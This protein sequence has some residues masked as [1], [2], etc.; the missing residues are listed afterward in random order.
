MSQWFVYLLECADGSYYTGITTDLERRV[1]EH[2]GGQRGA[3]YTRARQ[4]V[5]L[6]YHE[7][8][9]SRSEASQREYAIRTL[10]RTGKQHLA[11]GSQD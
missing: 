9:A 7:T 5:T 8:A 2:N 11:S 1:N 4:P 3:R 10:P 6:V